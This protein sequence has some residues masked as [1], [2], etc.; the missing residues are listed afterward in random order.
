M[1]METQIGPEFAQLL[2]SLSMPGGWADTT[3]YGIG[4]LNPQQIAQAFQQGSANRQAGMR[5]Q[6]AERQQNMEWGKAGLQ[7]A[8][9]GEALNW[10]REKFP[11]QMAVKREEIGAKRDVGAMKAGFDYSKLGMQEQGKNARA[12]ERNLVE[13]QRAAGQDRRNDLVEQGLLQRDRPPPFKPSPMQEMQI[14]KDAAAFTKMGINP[15]DAYA[16]AW[17][18]MAESMAAAQSGAKE[19][20]Q[21]GTPTQPQSAQPVVPQQPPA[22][23][24]PDVMQTGNINDMPLYRMLGIGTNRREPVYNDEPLNL[25]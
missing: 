21:G 11:E 16:R 19:V 5:D 2:Q 24:P 22:P 7:D 1:V 3:A 14:Q 12:K 20:W 17:R 18:E 10:E 23:L 15:K 6:L 4:N 13:Q 8:R 9:A 25:P